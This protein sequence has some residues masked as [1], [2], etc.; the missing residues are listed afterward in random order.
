MFQHAPMLPIFDVRFVHPCHYKSV[1]E[2]S[3]CIR[4]TY[5]GAGL[6]PCM[7]N[8]YVRQVLFYGVSVLTINML[9]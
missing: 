6:I 4:L 2:N 8:L 9:L 1:P 5:S 7:N 3:F